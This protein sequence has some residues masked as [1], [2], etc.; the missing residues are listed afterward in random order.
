M[1]ADSPLSTVT[2][3]DAGSPLNTVTLTYIF[4]L[5]ASVYSSSK[6]ISTKALL[7]VAVYSPYNRIS[8]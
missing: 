4:H 3:T 6:R 2:L 8:V 5:T 7:T 1:Y